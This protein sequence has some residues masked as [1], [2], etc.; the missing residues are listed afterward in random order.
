MNPAFIDN[1]VVTAIQDDFRSRAQRHRTRGPRRPTSIF[2]RWDRSAVELRSTARTS[3]ASVP[4][5]TQEAPS[6]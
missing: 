3:L 1:A 2:S 5:V 4:R 6:Q